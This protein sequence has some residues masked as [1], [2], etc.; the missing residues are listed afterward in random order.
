MQCVMLTDATEPTLTISPDGPTTV[1][2]D[3]VLS[4]VVTVVEGLVVAP[5]VEWV[6]YQGNA[7]ISENT[8]TNGSVYQRDIEFNPLQALHGG[9]YV[10]SASVSIP[11]A[12]VPLLSNNQSYILVAQSKLMNKHIIIDH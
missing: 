8:T 9:L 3:V 4:C 2:M 6:L 5:T 7:T 11:S 10:C 12:S 1:G